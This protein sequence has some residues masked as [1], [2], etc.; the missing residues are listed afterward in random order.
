MWVSCGMR[1]SRIS[2]PWFVNNADPSASYGGEG[3]DPVTLGDTSWTWDVEFDPSSSLIYAKTSLITFANLDA[4]WG[5]VV[6]GIVAYRTRNADGSD[7]THLV[8]QSN[9]NG[10]ADWVA[11]TNVDSVTFGWLIGAGGTFCQAGIVMEVWGA[12]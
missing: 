3:P 4:N 5:L 12:D 9:P 10:T 11:D 6:S 8:G 1:S 7:A 2:V